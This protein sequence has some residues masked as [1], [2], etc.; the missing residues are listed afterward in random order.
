VGII[1]I[2]LRQTISRRF[3][4]RYLALPKVQSKVADKGVNVGRIARAAS[5]NGIMKTAG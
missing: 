1:A 3:L 5:M 2:I 4:M